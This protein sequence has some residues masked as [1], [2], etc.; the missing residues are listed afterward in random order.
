MR[1]N[2]RKK[3]TKQRYGVLS[4]ELGF[5]TPSLTQTLDG[6]EGQRMLNMYQIPLR[7]LSAVVLGRGFFL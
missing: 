3:P 4:R 1:A 7:G 6:I 2:C 5:A